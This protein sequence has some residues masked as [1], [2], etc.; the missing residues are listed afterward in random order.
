MMPYINPFCNTVRDDT[1]NI[2]NKKWIL[3]I[4]V[5]S[6]TI[7]GDL[8]TWIVASSK[9]MGEFQ[10]EEIICSLLGWYPEI[11]ELSVTDDLTFNGSM[12]IF[13]P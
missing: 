3:D 9:S 6:M 8:S 5:F 4:D 11:A 2:M 12:T 1:F 10:N 7:K 13:L